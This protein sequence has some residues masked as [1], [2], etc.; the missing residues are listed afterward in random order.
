MDRSQQEP[1]HRGLLRDWERVHQGMS[2]SLNLNQL[3][4]IQQANEA[5]Q[6]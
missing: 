2:M 1:P 6:A 4:L 5:W 3:Q